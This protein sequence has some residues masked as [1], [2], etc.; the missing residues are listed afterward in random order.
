M[1]ALVLCTSLSAA[2]L[3]H[4]IA[5]SAVVGYQGPDTVV[6]GGFGGNLAYHLRVGD[7]FVAHAAAGPRL[8]LAP[9]LEIDVGAGWSFPIGEHWRITTGL[10]GAMMAVGAVRRVSTDDI[11]P[12]MGPPV[13]ARIFVRPIEYQQ[14]HLVVRALGLAAGVGL[15]APAHSLAI[16]VNLFEV[17]WSI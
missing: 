15:D 8:Y 17:G 3:A 12:I 1:I 7:H 4:E 2:P 5:V 16:G 14:D 10:E 13:A 6:A 9:A 11:T